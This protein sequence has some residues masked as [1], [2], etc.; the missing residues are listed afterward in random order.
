M[1]PVAAAPA[2]WPGD[3]RFTVGA[4][5]LVAPILDASGVRD[6]ALP[7]GD[8][9]WDWWD[10]AAGARAGGTVVAAYDARAA[11]RV[12]LFVRA[13]A[14]VPAE[15]AD[16]AL[17]LGTAASA[18]RITLLVWA[19]GAATQVDVVEVDGSTRRVT[20]EPTPG[21]YRITRGPAA[22]DA[23]RAAVVRFVTRDDV[24]R[25]GVDGVAATE[26]AGRDA[27]DA[28]D[29]GWWRDAT[30]PGVWVRLRAG[31]AAQVVDL[32]FAVR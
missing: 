4:A 17:G 30:L 13:G 1:A 31:A 8:A 14:V 16:G 7:A 11:G 20:A 10:A 24:M 19:G 15:V 29:Q 28:T 6:V 3:H 2:D 18:G 12:P 27:L 21:G 25:A 5:F 32:H 22:G 9:W 23:M 26:A